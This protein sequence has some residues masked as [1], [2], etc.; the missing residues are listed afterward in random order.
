MLP[1]VIAIPSADGPSWVDIMT[2][3]GTVGA[4]MAVVGIA[5]WTEWRSDRRF[6]EERERSD[7][8]LADERAYGAAQVE[9]ERRIAREREQLA[10]AYAVQVV[11]AE[12][13]G[14]IL[15][16]E[17]GGGKQLGVIIVNRGRL[18]VSRMEVQFSP[19]AMSLVP[20]FR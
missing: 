17:Q 6:R 1:V 14:R 13:P 5:L 3:F 19:D 12:V 18:T 16:D 20:H 4:V 10:E 8:L 11:P 15:N 2:A 7:R 9:E